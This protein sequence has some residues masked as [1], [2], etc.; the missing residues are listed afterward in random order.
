MTSFHLSMS[1]HASLQPSYTLSQQMHLHSFTPTVSYTSYHPPTLTHDLFSPLCHPT[2]L[3][4]YPYRFYTPSVLRYPIYASYQ[5]PMYCYYILLHSYVIIRVIYSL[6]HTFLQYITILHS[7]AILRICT[8]D[9]THCYFILS[10][11]YA[12]IYVFFQSPT[13]FYNIL[14]QLYITSYTP[15][16]LLHLP[17]FLRSQAVKV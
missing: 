15:S 5:A 1:F 2:S 9:P 11:S 8:H 12:M 4:N 10:Y 3:C 17:S 14:L 7:Y 16:F 13:P 6:L